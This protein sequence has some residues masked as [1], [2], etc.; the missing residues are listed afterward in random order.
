MPTADESALVSVSKKIDSKIQQ[1]D[2]NG[3]LRD[4]Y[5]IVERIVTEPVCTG[6]AYGSH[7]LDE[8]CKKI[9]K[10]NLSAIKV[11]PERLQRENG[12]PATYVYIVTKVLRAGGHI[13]VIEDF[14]NCSPGS[15]H[16]L[17]ST[18]LI[19][20]SDSG[21]ADS[22]FL[23]RN[24]VVIEHGRCRSFLAKL[25]WLQTRLLEIDSSR[26]YLF[27]H[28]QD[29]VAASAIQPEMNLNAYF[30]HHADYQLCLGV[31]MK[32][33]KHID[34]HPMGYE[35]CRKNLGV[36]NIYVPLVVES[37]KR[38]FKPH[39]FKKEGV[40]TTCTSAKSNKVE[41]SY[42]VSY[43]DMVPTLLAATGGRHLHIGRLTPWALYRIRRGLNKV[44]VPSDRFIYKPWVPSVWDELVDNHVDIYIASFPYGGGLTLIEAMGAG[45]PVVLHKHLY[46]RVLSSIDLA[47][48]GVLYWSEL[49]DLLDYCVKMS[50]ADYKQFSL[51]GRRQYERF[52]KLDFLEKFVNDSDFTFSLPSEKIDFVVEKDK[53]VIWLESQITVSH[54]IKRNIYRMYRRIRAALF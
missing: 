42:Y 16:I 48:S 6:Q 2:F 40:L 30:Y 21:Y 53:C 23:G 51:D 12:Y 26:V 5:A 28:N 39:E 50:A 9:G 10:H 20:R 38:V 14:I 24:N 31:C 46:S 11:K 33:L 15:N 19:G 3:A 29:S 34:P 41:V 25:N 4:I 54:V 27:N 36:D 13:K 1:A 47:Y 35:N 49:D 45:V 17:L 43:L 22:K 18:E 52:H 32:H 7:V 44:G 8:L 37:N